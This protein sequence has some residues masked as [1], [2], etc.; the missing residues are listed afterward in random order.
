[1]TTRHTKPTAARAASRPPALRRW[2]LPVTLAAVALGTAFIAGMVRTPADQAARA[3]ASGKARLFGYKVVHVYPHDRQA[4]TQGLIYRDGVLFES[5]GLN[6]RSSLRKVRL[7]TGEVLERRPVDAE[8]FAEGLT[9]WGDGLIQ[10]TWK[11]G[12]AFVYAKEKFALRKTFTYTGEGWGLTHDGQ[13]LVM[14]D[15][16]AALRFLDP[17][18][19]KETSRLEVKDRGLPVDRLNELEWVK[20][21]IFANIWQTDRLAIVSPK[22][23]QVTGWVDLAGLLSP[24]DIQ[25][26]IDV[27][28]GIAYDDNKNRL[29]V[30]G[31]LWPKLFEIELVPR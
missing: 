23:G 25:G 13:R 21:E 31:K 3:T 26:E 19:F 8:Y 6:G 1:M 12:L 22:S 27:L 29:F 2:T 9:D 4:F 28:N 24:A 15:G 5:T 7:E 30:T 11:N 10:L 16:S 17:T 14:S 20:G 18:T